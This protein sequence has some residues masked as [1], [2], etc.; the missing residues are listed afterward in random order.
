MSLFSKR[1][2]SVNFGENFVHQHL[3]LSYDREKHFCLHSF[4]GNAISLLNWSYLLWGSRFREKNMQFSCLMLNYAFGFSI[5]IVSIFSKAYNFT[6]VTNGSSV[7]ILTCLVSIKGHTHLNK[8]T[9]KSTKGTKTTGIVNK[10][11]A[12]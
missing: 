5:Y 9:T 7:L 2:T 4:C 12:G 11:A 8:P 1:W 6:N 10:R 3:R